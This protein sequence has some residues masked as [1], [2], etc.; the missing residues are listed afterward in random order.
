MKTDEFLHGKRRRRGRE[1]N[2]RLV[3]ASRAAARLFRGEQQPVRGC[4]RRRLSLELAD[5][6]VRTA[7]PP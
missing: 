1:A 7:P 2:R 3:A 4:R 5:M 6:L